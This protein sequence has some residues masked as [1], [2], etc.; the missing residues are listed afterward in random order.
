VTEQSP[1]NFLLLLEMMA[2][3]SRFIIAFVVIATFAA[4]IISLVLPKWY[5]ATATLLPSKQISVQGG[6]LSEF[7]EAVSVTSGLD[8]PIMVTSSD[9]YARMLKSKTIAEQVMKKFNLNERY[10][11]YSFDETYDALMKKTDFRVTAEG[12]LTV[13]VEDKVPQMAADLANAFVEE[14][15]KVNREIASKRATQNR[16]FIEERLLQVKE[17]LDSARSRFEQFQMKNKTVDFDQ[18]TRLVTERAVGLKV[19]QAEIDLDL[20]LAMQEL[21]PDNPKVVEL[22]RKRKIITDQIEKL[23]NEN[24][25]NSYFSVPISKIPTLRGQYEMLYSQVKVNETLYELLLEQREKA[26]IQISENSPTISVLD[27]ARVPSIRSRPQRT[28]IVVATFGFSLVI[29]ILGTATSEYFSNLRKH[30]PEQYRSV[31]MF[32]TSFFGW[33][34]GIRKKS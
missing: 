9:V 26:K 32:L 4:V 6:G 24:P 12:L 31:E 13:S 19:K 22:K 5:K 8:L 11:T 3:R 7:A 34:P 25:D 1:N 29:A 14:L 10:E 28:L 16:D 21:S 30:H 23:E 20:D 2:R 27:Q 18:Q 17:E 15:D 33:L